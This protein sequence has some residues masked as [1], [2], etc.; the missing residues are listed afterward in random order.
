MNLQQ[1]ITLFLNRFKKCNL[2]REQ[3]RFIN[4]AIKIINSG[5]LGL[6]ESPTGTGKTRSILI[7]VLFY[8]NNSLNLPIGLSQQNLVLLRSLYSK[9]NKKVFYVCR[10]HTQLLEILKELEY[11]NKINNTTVKGVVLSSRKNTCINNKVKQSKNINDSC[12]VTVKNGECGFYNSNLKNPT[13]PEIIRV[14]KK[15]TISI[16][17]A[18]EL[19][20]NCNICPYF[21]LKEQSKSAS[22]IILPYSLLLQ[23]GFLKENTLKDSVLVIDEAHNFYSSVI[24]EYSVV[25][26]LDEISRITR[27]FKEYVK[28]KEGVFRIELLEV[29]IFMNRLEEY[30]KGL[31]KK[32][33]VAMLGEKEKKSVSVR[34]NNELQKKQSVTI[35]P[36]NESKPVT[37]LN[38]NRFLIESGLDS[39]P[40]L[41]IYTNINKYYLAQRVFTAGE[42]QD[43]LK[44]IG[45]LC[46]LLGESEKNSYL[47]LNSSEI[48]LKTLFPDNF[49]TYF[50]EFKSI[51][52]IGGTLHPS[53]DIPDLFQRK[54]VTKQYSAI[55][56]NIEVRISKDY[57]FNYTGRDKEIE[58]VI[59]LV[60]KIYREIKTGGI[61]LFV[62]SKQV[63]NQLKNHLKNKKSVTDLKIFTFE[64]TIKLEEYKKIIRKDKKIVMVCIMNG[65]FSEGINFNDELCRVLIICGIPLPI[66]TE[67][68]LLIERHKGK[69]YF[70]S[71]GMQIVNQTIGR[72]VR[73]IND[74][75]YVLLL[76][77]RF[78]KYK[79]KLS[80]WMEPYVRTE[81]RTDLVER[82]K[83]KLEDWKKTE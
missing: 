36:N 39:S 34:D 49:I 44:R 7:T 14:S 27:I 24:S 21:Y 17:D 82:I 51:L 65:I 19:G 41:D 9:S 78:I 31:E 50:S 40:V 58:K 37:I 48:A 76:D 43:A 64:G 72:A 47:L 79:D 30:L 53:C 70:I 75:S 54:T 10:T 57:L 63:L 5:Y 59:K 74:Y 81:D 11:L 13:N 29:L 33:S 8:L 26:R 12:R 4:D 6:L 28:D 16:E 38:I 18:V 56:K 80:K 67:E 83:E 22:V 35:S 25:L 60:L 62:Q 1:E 46:K 3:L 71:K 66:P 42:D 20:N 69:E 55:C 45:K 52:A 77:K 2:Y 23:E 32:E 15:T 68:V 61:L 73:T